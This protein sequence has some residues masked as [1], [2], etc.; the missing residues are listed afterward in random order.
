MRV[1]G[2]WCRMVKAGYT[3]SAGC[4][5]LARWGLRDC[6]KRMSEKKALNERITTKREQKDSEQETATS[7][8]G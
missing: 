6:N 4:G 8:N 5:G 3:R 1:G 7:A 2:L